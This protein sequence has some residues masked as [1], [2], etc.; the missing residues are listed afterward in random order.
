M[1]AVIPGQCASIEPG[2]SRFSDVQLHIFGPRFA[3]SGMT[4]EKCVML[5]R[6]RKDDQGTAVSADFTH[7]LTREILGTELLRVRTILATLAVLLA[8]LLIGYAIWPQAIDRIWHGHLPIL[9]LAA[10]FV[11]FVLF[12]LSVLRLIKARLKQGGDVPRARRYLGVLI[13]T[14]L[15]TVA[16]YLEMKAMGPAQALAFVVPLAYFIFIILS[17]LRLDFWLSTFTGFV[18]AAELF[19][20]AML[21]RPAQFAAEPAPDIAFHIVRCVVILV[22]GVLAGA[23]GMQLRRQFEAS[24]LAATARDRITNLFG[25]H[26]SPQVVERLMAEGKSTDSEIRRV[27]VMFVDFR[28]FTAGA[29]TRTPRE[30]V[31]RLDGAFA[32]LVEILDRHGGIVN[33]FLGDGFL[34]LFGAP[35]DAPHPARHA[36]AAAREMLEVN[37]RA[38]REASW[39]L[40]IG[41]GIHVG[42]V[43]AGNIGSPRRKE[44]TVIGD[45]VNFAARLEA[46]NKEFNSQFLISSAV[47]EA[48]GQDGGDAIS[49]GEVAIRGYDRPMTV[50]QLG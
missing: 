1:L 38:N 13:E 39:P 37:E 47:H 35:L 50:W 32:A 36:V 42:E 6:S 9:P 18:A 4:T 24:I 26:V 14:S 17:T 44:Y 49:L 7:A 3:C 33:K 10:V 12:E 45:T 43:V 15:P 25:Q 8:A 23:V 41:I 16:L 29:S 46:L 19:G 28:S 5:W 34:A 31:D 21:Y 40:R 20:M 30:V 11:P 2:I 48:L 22:C 27:A